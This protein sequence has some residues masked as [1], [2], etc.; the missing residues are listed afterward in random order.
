MAINP[1]EPKVKRFIT[2]GG[3]S[4]FIRYNSNFPMVV[5]T[6]EGVDVRYQVWSTGS[7]LNFNDL[8]GSTDELMGL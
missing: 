3:E 5:Y 4:Y 7:L 6:P 1:N 2:L 8:E